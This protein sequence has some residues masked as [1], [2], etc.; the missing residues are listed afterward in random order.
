[1]SATIKTRNE[2]FAKLQRLQ[3]GEWIFANLS[4]KLLVAAREFD[5]EGTAT[6]KEISGSAGT[7]HV[8][9]RNF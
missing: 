1:M 6:L 3:K 9:V 4:P 8:L 7:F 5:A 2:L